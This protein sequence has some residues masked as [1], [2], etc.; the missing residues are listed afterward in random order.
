M[1]YDRISES[2]VRALFSSEMWEYLFHP[3]IDES[4]V[5]PRCHNVPRCFN[6]DASTGT[7]A[8]SSRFPLHTARTLVPSVLATNVFYK[9][10][11]LQTLLCSRRSCPKKYIQEQG[12]NREYEECFSKH[13]TRARSYGMLWIRAGGASQN[14]YHDSNRPATLTMPRSE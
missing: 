13:C 4:T 12:S 14:G 6:I 1:S 9:T 3:A 5:L 11:L 10:L 7:A 8:A 2:P